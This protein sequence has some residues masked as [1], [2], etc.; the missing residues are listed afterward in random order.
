VDDSA[1]RPRLATDRSRGRGFWSP[2]RWTLILLAANVVWRLVRYGVGFP[3]WG[4]EAYVAVNIID[5]G[6]GALMLPLDH[7]Q[8]APIAFLWLERAVSQT[9]GLSEHALR[10]VPFGAGVASLFVFHRLVRRVLPPRQALLALAIF[11]ASYYPVRHAAEIKPYSIDMLVS[12]LLLTAA[13]RIDRERGGGGWWAMLTVVSAAGVWL[14][15]PAVFVAGGV[16]AVLGVRALMR[17]ATTSVVLAAGAGAALT[18]SFIAMFALVGTGQSVDGATDVVANHWAYTFPDVRRPWTLPGWFFKIHAGN[19]LAYPLGGRNGGSAF[20]LVLV[21][22]GIVALW[23]RREQATVLLLLAPLPLMF[24]AAALEKYPYGGSA[25][26]SQHLAPAICILAGVGIVALARTIVGPRMAVHVTRIFMAGMVVIAA[27]GAARDV[28]EP[29]KKF[30][31]RENLRIMRSFAPRIGPND[32]LVVFGALAGTPDTPRLEPWGGSVARIR[33]NLIRFSPV[34][35]E[36]G[37]A[38]ATLA[39]PEDGTLWLFVYRD[40]K[41]AFPE[42][43]LAAYLEKVETRLGAPSIEHHSLGERA[44]VI[45]LYSWGE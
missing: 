45:T 1:S 14:S 20:T 29:Y 21:A 32:R 10:L 19:M 40:N 31:D 42:E 35:I 12:L 23:R 44:E 30:A 24:V 39:V 25:R 28:L 38:P 16:I 41:V 5:R 8:I 37:P 2:A 4:D 7:W 3:I 13:W 18:A 26:V 9:L 36:W 33:F 34:E 27:A 17:R 6:Y 22:A 43:M 15:Y 11:A